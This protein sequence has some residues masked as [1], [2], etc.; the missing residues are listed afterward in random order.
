M[1]STPTW[2]VEGVPAEARALAESAALA[3]DLPLGPW[4][5][6][7]ISRAAEDGANPR[8][9]RLL[10]QDRPTGELAIELVRDSLEGFR[11]WADGAL[12]RID[13]LSRALDRAKI[14]L[15]DT[16]ARAR[17][18]ERRAE[19]LAARIERLEAKEPAQRNARRSPTAAELRETLAA[20][21]DVAES[22]V[23]ESLAAE[24]RVDAMDMTARV[25]GA[26]IAADD[27]VAEPA[28]PSG[29]GRIEPT[30]DFEP[31]PD[32]SATEIEHEIEVEIEAADADAAAPRKT[33]IA[34][35]LKADAPQKKQNLFGALAAV[36][37][38]RIAPEHADEEFEAREIALD[39]DW[40]DASA[41]ADSA[42]EPARAFAELISAADDKAQD[43]VDARESAEGDDGLDIRPVSTR[44]LFGEAPRAATTDEADDVLRADQDE[45]TE[46][47]D[48]LTIDL[49]ADRNDA[50]GGDGA[51]GGWRLGSALR[52]GETAPWRRTPQSGGLARSIEPAMELA[53][54]RA[55]QGWTPAP[56]AAGELDLGPLGR[57]GVVVLGLASAA[58][59]VAYLHAFA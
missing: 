30:I 9:A 5:T 17:R 15:R 55:F 14:S 3:R 35:V 49:S 7:A 50:L 56:S 13:D 36:E 19:Q 12:E 48:P 58:M 22:L 41:V 28:W 51:S 43:D 37:A 8:R 34:S 27:L 26:D 21:T 32:A 10:D 47:R 25:R 1:T 33:D 39:L 16:D 42:L 4:L 45:P 2:S 24:T 44:A 40:S 46:R 23:A 54:D 29:D 20:K 31:S 57:G 11:Y 52:R 6:H 53:F 38:A 59:L 18:A